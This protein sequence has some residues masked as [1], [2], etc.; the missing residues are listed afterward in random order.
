MKKFIF[1][2]TIVLFGTLVFT[3]ESVAN[4][5]DLVTVENVQFDQ[6]DLNLEELISCGFPVYY[7]G[8]DG[9]GDFWFDCDDSTSWDDVWNWIMQMFF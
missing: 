2:L 8:D 1:G 7:Q 5:Y 4:S 9:F 3:S 6:V